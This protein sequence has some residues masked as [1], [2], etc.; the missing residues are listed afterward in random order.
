MEAREGKDGV[1]TAR[2]H[3]QAKAKAALI[4]LREKVVLWPPLLFTQ[5]R[6]QR[7]GG[8]RQTHLSCGASFGLGPGPT[9]HQTS[10]VKQGDEA[11]SYRRV[12]SESGLGRF[13][14]FKLGVQN[15]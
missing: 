5:S 10:Q 3:Q 1:S 9:F 15:F 8:A 11:E 6:E 14:G 2:G 13:R 12:F 7:E 4:K